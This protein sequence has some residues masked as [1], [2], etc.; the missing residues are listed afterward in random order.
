MEGIVGILQFAID[1]LSQRQDAIANNLANDYTPGYTAQQVNFEQSLQQAMANPGGGTASITVT[2]S[3]A[4]ATTNGNNVDTGQQLISASKA[5]LQYQTMVALL[6][7]QIGIV[8]A[9]VGGSSSAT[10]P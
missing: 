7:A 1:G 10:V 6:N 9:A 3:T 8:A 4:P 2:S 5:E